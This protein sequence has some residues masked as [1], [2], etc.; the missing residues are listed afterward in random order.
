[1]MSGRE[2]LDQPRQPPRGARGPSRCAARAESG[3]APRC[4]RRRS[5]PP[6][7]ATSAARWPIARRPLTVSST[8]FWPPRQVRAVSMW[9][10]NIG[11]QAQTSATANQLTASASSR[12]ACFVAAALLLQLPQLRELQEH[13]VRVQRRDDAARRAP[14]RMPP[15]SDVVAQERQRRMAGELRAAPARRP[16]RLHLLAP[17]ASCSDR[18]SRGDRRCRGRRSAG[19]RRAAAR[20][21]PRTVTAS[22]TYRPVHRAG[23][24]IVEAQL[25]VRIPVGGPDPSAQVPRDARNAIAGVRRA[26]RERARGSR[27]PAPASPAR[28][29]RATGSSRASRA[30]RRGSSARRSRASRGPRRGRCAG[31]RSP[32]SRRCCRSRRRR[33]RRPRPPTSSAASMC[34][35]SFQVMTVTV[36]F[37]RGSVPASARP[38]TERTSPI[39]GR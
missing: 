22:C 18:S 16:L 9:R 19:A 23:A 28:R 11:Y 29:R 37:T 35:A 12:C 32:R 36:S 24:P 1:M 8:W 20:I 6:G 10:E 14:S 7:C 21:G 33:S 13:V 5:S 38:G 2:P 17:P 34:A 26:R 27:P 15:R 30:T 25:I 31:A 39:I 3:R 4:A